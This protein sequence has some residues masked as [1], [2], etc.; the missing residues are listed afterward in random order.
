MEIE[1]NVY[2]F[3]LA[4]LFRAFVVSV[5]VWL[6]GYCQ[7][8]VYKVLSYFVPLCCLGCMVGWLVIAKYMFSTKTYFPQ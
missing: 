3:C 6:N 8:N 5:A 7:V 2:K 1:V 4:F